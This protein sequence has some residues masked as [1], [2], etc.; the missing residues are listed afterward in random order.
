[1]K[2]IIPFVCLIALLTLLWKELYYAKPTELP[3]TLIGETIP[4]FELADLLLAKTFSSKD[5]VGHVS[6]LNVWSTWCYA[7]NL[8]HEMLM[9]IKHEYRVPIYGINYKD[10]PTNAIT[11]LQEHGNPYVMIGKDDTGDVAIDLGVYGT[12]ETFVINGYGQIVYRF[13]GPIDQK[14]WDEILYP[15]VKR[16]SGK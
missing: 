12:P 11:W 6:L 7:C 4:N 16:L 8:E 14:N 9:K 2:K 15:L 3:S 1:M 13:I 10:S 5:L